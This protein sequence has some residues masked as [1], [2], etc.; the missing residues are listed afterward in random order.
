MK[1]R[2][3]LMTMSA[4]EFKDAAVEE[5]ALAL[6]E[7]SRNYKFHKQWCVD[8]CGD[9]RGWLYKSHKSSAKWSRSKIEEWLNAINLE[10]TP[11]TENY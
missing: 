9:R 3:E 7:L 10:V 2:Y 5:K 6:N 1:D 8:Y 11:E 4:E